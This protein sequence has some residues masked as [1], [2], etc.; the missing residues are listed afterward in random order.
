[1]PRILD[2][3]TTHYALRTRRPSAGAPDED[4]WLRLDLHF[5]VE[6][7]ARGYVLAC[8]VLV[9]ILGPESFRERVVE[10]AR[11]VLALYGAED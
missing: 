1:M 4:G 5:E 7:D 3:E 8:G 11:S 9:E 6:E 10:L 2:H